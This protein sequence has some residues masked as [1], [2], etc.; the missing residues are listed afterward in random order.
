MKINTDL[1]LRVVIQQSDLPWLEAPAAGVQRRLLERDGQ[2]VARAT[3]VVRYAPGSQFSSHVHDLG[4]EIVVLDGVLTDEF[5][6]YGAGTY[7]KNPPGSSHAPASETGCTLFVKLRHLGR[8]D[9][10]RVVVDTSKKPWCPGLVSGLS[11]MPLSEFGAEHTALVR[12]APGTRFNAHCH[13]GGEEV[14]VL[15]GVFEDEH[16]HYPSGTWIRSP[17]LSEHRPFSSQG[18]TILVKTGHLLGTERP[19]ADDIHRPPP[20]EF[21]KTRDEAAFPCEQRGE[22]S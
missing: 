18:C 8:T 14:F 5:G 1:S 6:S 21:K 2:E 4:E 11:V 9:R 17:H 12:W 13:Y 15:E 20:V 19:Q 22:A 7:I 3:S 16:G 10:E